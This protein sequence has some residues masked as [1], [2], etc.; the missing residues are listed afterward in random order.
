MVDA[1]TVIATHLSELLKR[2]AHKLLGHE[3][4]QKLLDRLAASAP[5]LVENLT[6]GA[7]PLGVVVRVMQDLL[8]EKVPVRDMRTIAQALTEQAPRSQDPAALAPADLGTTP[9]R[10][11]RQPNEVRES[12]SSWHL[13]QLP[14]AATCVARRPGSV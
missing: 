11:A 9:T 6:P 7:L 1:S 5:K 13:P 12:L 10:K 2:H 8:A 3:E 4:V 14:E